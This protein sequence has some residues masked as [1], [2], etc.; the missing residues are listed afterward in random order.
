MDFVMR[1]VFPIV[2]LILLA[3]LII[4]ALLGLRRK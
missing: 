3:A 4:V 1:V 2:V